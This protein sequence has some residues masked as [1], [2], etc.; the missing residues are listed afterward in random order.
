VLGVT[1]VPGSQTYTDLFPS[2]Q[3]R[4]AFATE[5]QLRLAVTRGIARPNY[6][7]LAPHLAGT[8]GGNKSNPANLSSGNPDLRPQH[9]WNYDLMLEHF[10]NSVGVIS[11]G[12]FYKSINDLIVNQTFV[13]TGPVSAFVGQAGTR[14]TNVGSG[15]LLGFEAEWTQR[16]TSLPGL[17]NGL[18]FDANYTHVDSRALVD[19]STSR[20]APLPR[21]SP[22]LGNFGLTYDRGPVSG[23]AA[24]SYQG[25]NIV[26]YGDGT[27]TANGDNYFYAHSQIDASLS[28]N[29]TSAVQIQFQALNLNNAVFGFFN[30]TPKQDYSIQREY[31]GRT[32]Y[33]GAKY[34]L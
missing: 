25:A 34:G 17:F 32:F 22:N 14:P 18:G 13:Y 20:Y 2:A 4:F 3:V 8:V 23:R 24:L 16:L 30:G 26:S 15:H 1:T 7:D 11:G 21:Q 9:A 5:T 19:P 27:A 29:F 28:Y 33:L 10:F 12:V 6:S 31:Y